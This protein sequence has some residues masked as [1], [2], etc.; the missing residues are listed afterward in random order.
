[1]RAPGTWVCTVVA[2]LAA[3]PVW[4]QSAPRVD[5]VTRGE[6]ATDLV[7]DVV[8]NETQ[9]SERTSH[10]E[11]RSERVTPDQRVVRE[12]VE[13]ASGP[14]FRV[15]EQ[16]GT[17][18][19]SAQQRQE[20]AR[21]DEYLSDPTAVAAAA[22]THNQDQDRI[23]TAMQLLPAALVFE[24]QE[25]PQGDMARLA[26]HP[27]PAFTPNSFEARIVHALSGTVTVD[28]RHKRMIAMEGTVA[29]RVDFGFGFLGHVDQGGTFV[30]HRRQVGAEHW[31]TDLV[32]IHV[33][34]K[35]LL[36]KTFSKDQREVRTDF[37]RVPQNT[38]LAQAKEMLDQTPSQGAEALLGPALRGER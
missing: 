12:Q 17:P 27:N 29:Q 21:L 18:L 34:G 35:I 36:M 38:T 7:R 30:I 6:S 4:A 22:R 19:D 1:M 32:D 11:Y 5:A 2:A 13:T 24:Y 20:E 25:T 28:A 8:Y 9:D 10:W 33:E 14:V 26:F 16:N 31:K 37:R 3:L 15:I 23:T